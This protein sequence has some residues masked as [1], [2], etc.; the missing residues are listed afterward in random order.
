MDRETHAR[1]SE[2]LVALY[3]LVQLLQ[4][5]RRSGV[6]IGG[7]A[8]GLLGYSRA[9]ADIDMIIEGTGIDLTDF[10]EQARTA[11][12]EPRVADALEFARR[13]YVVPLKHTATGV[14]ID[15]SLA[16]TPFEHEAIA[17]AVSVSL[18][19]VSAPVAH[20]EDLV[21]MKCVAQRPIDR[22]DIQELYRIYAS[23]IDLNRVR[24]WVEQF[25]EAFD[26]PDLWTRVAPL[27]SA[28]ER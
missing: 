9:T 25:A 4:G 7:V 26:D 13:T 19:T 2:F 28:D 8:V 11:G 1:E 22:V 18:P 10:L 16:F 27:F 14:P 20:P 23:Q 6:L 15:L 3:D 12:F 24:Y 17:N 5:T 21:I